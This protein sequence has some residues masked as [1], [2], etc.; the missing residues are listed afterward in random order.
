MCGFEGKD[1][2]F[3]YKHRNKLL[4]EKYSLCKNLCYK[5]MNE[6]IEK[7]HEVLRLLNIG[8]LYQNYL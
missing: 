5:R 8:L 6:S 7:F 4:D 1:T 2:Y 3:F